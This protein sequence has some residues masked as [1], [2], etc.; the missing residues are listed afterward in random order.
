LAGRIQELPYQ[1][2]CELI[3]GSFASNQSHNCLPF[4]SCYNS[5][6][7]TLFLR[8]AQDMAITVEAVYEHGV[9]K[10][11]EPLPWKEGERV[12]VEISSLDSP[13]LKAYGIMGF[14][15]TA[16]EADYFAQ[17]PELDYPLPLEEA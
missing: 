12:R 10:P 13:L 6:S 14:K 9:L 5:I 11:A 15:G 8:G 2:R 17:D 1:L 16:E 7:T 4:Y 3:R